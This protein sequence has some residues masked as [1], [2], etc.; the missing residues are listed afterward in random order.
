MTKDA[1]LCHFCPVLLSLKHFISIQLILSLGA[2]IWH[3]GC[4]FQAVTRNTVFSLLYYRHSE[5]SVSSFICTCMLHQKHWILW[6]GPAQTIQKSSQLPQV[7]LWFFAWY[8]TAIIICTNSVLQVPWFVSALLGCAHLESS[9][10]QCILGGSWVLPLQL[11]ASCS[12]CSAELP[13]LCCTCYL[14]C[15]AKSITSLNVFLKLNNITIYTGSIIIE[16]I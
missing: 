14:C 9:L 3:C 16:D 15:R 6:L 5:A 13:S 11:S 2:W 10:H 7:H 8:Y 4:L 12:R 1:T